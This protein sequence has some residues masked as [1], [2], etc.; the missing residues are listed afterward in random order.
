MSGRRMD[1]LAGQIDRLVGQA[2][3]RKVEGPVPEWILPPPSCEFL[4]SLAA[5]LPGLVTAFEF[6]SGRSTHALR[7]ACAETMSV[8]DS[9]EWLRETETL[10]EKKEG[11]HTFVIPL[12]RRW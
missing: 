4:E 9:T 5:L 12:R 7:R 6:G 1:T 10:G 11:D 2:G 8:D 3:A